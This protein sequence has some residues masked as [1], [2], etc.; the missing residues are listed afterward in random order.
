MLFEV[1]FDPDAKLRSRIKG[2][3]FNELFA[4][5]KFALLRESFD[6]ISETLVASRG[7]FY[8]VPG[9]TG[10][11]AVTVKTA[12]VK[13]AYEIQGI[14]INGNNVLHLEDDEFG[15]DDDTAKM[16]VRRGTSIF[17][18]Q[19]SHELIVPLRSLKITYTP[20]EAAQGALKY[21]LG[22]SVRKA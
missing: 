8:S 3:L 19:L 14:Y 7:D 12:K 13:D 20:V 16:F 5:Q 6:F 22:Y 11:L 4:L 21:P 18:E 2:N 10:E 15:A 9:K 17:E 1:F